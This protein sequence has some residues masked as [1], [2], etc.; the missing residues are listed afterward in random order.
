MSLIPEDLHSYSHSGLIAMAD[1][2]TEIIDGRAP[3]YKLPAKFLASLNELRAEIDIEIEH[4]MVDMEEQETRWL[5]KAIPE[6][7]VCLSPRCPQ[8]IQQAS[9]SSL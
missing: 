1:L 9:T 6:V 8:I 2:M 4:V 5:P 3:D 7:E